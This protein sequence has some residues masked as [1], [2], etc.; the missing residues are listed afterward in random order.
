MLTLID[1]ETGREMHVQSNSEALRA[2]YAQAAAARNE[3]IVKRIR[4]AGGDHLALTTDRDWL[5]DIVKFV[6]HRRVARPGTPRSVEQRS[7][8]KVLEMRSTS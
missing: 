3:E 8:A 7:R 5:I 2:K 1:T 4:A 6:A